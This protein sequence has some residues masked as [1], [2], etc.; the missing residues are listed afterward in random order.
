M[1][2]SFVTTG[3]VSR[4]DA[5]FDAVDIDPDR[6]FNPGMASVARR[7][8]ERMRMLEWELTGKH[9]SDIAPDTE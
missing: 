7:Q 9:P 5:Y 1:S 3:D 8:V 6:E 4:I 2:E